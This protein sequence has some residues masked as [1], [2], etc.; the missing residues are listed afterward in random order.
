M[1]RGGLPCREG[2]DE[3]NHEYDDEEME[4]NLSDAGRGGQMPV[5]PNTRR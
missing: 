4:K 1:S 2:Q 3:E 5:K